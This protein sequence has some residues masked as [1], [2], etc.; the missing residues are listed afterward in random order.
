MDIDELFEKHGSAM[1]RLADTVSSSDVFERQFGAELTSWE[2]KF[3]QQFQERVSSQ[4]MRYRGFVHYTKDTSLILLSPSPWLLEGIY[5]Y[6]KPDQS[7]PTEGSMVEISGRSIAVPKLL[8]QGKGVVRAVT[9]DSVTPITVDLFSAIS[10]SLS[11]K[12]LSNILF[13]NVGMAEASKRVFARLFVSSPP[14]QESV[15]GLTT[16]IQAIASKA[17]V[18]KLF[19]F[20]KNVLPPAMRGK[21]GTHKDVRGVK[22]PIPKLWRLDV[23]PASKSKMDSLCVERKDPAGFREVS[24]GSLTNKLTSVLPDVPIALTSEEFYVETGNPTDLKLPILKAAITFQLLTPQVSQRSID[25]GTKHVVSRLEILRD[26]FGLDDKSLARGHVLDADALGRPLSAIR[27]AKSSARAYWKDKITSKD[28]K[29]AWDRILEPALREFIEL[30]QVKDDATDRWG[31]DSRFD[32]YNTSVLRAL[33]KLDSGKHGSLG[34]TLDEIAEEAGIERHETAKEL[35]QMKD[36][37]TVY[38]PKHGH[39]RFV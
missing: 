7:F 6:F 23:G 27:L 2:L 3:Q 39:Y 24:L 11:L 29:N 32:R 21:N 20:M 5:V 38:E 30:T 17:K 10:P 9:A 34:P 28:L 18:R 12:E 35:V 16:G 1:D 31:A 37:G 25:A 14:F 8:A 19:S 15:G 22:V 13:E 36:D 26:S 4:I 33:Q